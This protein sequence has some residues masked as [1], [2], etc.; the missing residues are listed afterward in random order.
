VISVAPQSA[1]GSD[2]YVDI[3]G[4]AAMK[5]TVSEP[6]SVWAL[7]ITP[8]V[9]SLDASELDVVQGIRLIPWEYVSP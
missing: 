8:V 1:P 5:I 9:S 6:N 2:S 7:A 3:I 4:Y